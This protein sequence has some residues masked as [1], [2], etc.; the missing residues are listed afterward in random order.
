M[1]VPRRAL[2][3]LTIVACI[4][5]LVMV[6][7]SRAT[8]TLEQDREIQKA[9]PGIVEAVKGRLGSLYA[10]LTFNLTTGKFVIPI[11]PG[12]S[13]AMVEGAIDRAPAVYPLVQHTLI[14]LQGSAASLEAELHPL[15]A[16]GKAQVMVDE[17]A[18][19]PRVYYA[20]KLPTETKEGVKAM[21]ASYGG[22]AS[23]SPTLLARPDSCSIAMPPKEAGGYCDDQPFGG[24][25]IWETP[26]VR[27]PGGDP[28][29]HAG[30]SAGFVVKS[31]QTP[32]I[33]TAGHCVKDTKTP[34]GTWV[35]REVWRCKTPPYGECALV[36]PYPPAGECI[37]HVGP[38]QQDEL[39]DFG[40]RAG[41]PA[42]KRP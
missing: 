20:S 8:V 22:A 24:V 25:T 37:L 31:G 41:T 6:G 28:L 39:G 32:V 34:S 3:V 42:K 7:E 30:C 29:P 12:A 40:W 19:K 5:F 10:G 18:N 27:D 26:Y 23:S 21:A 17:K 33:L 15:I 38:Y 9:H 11:A 36:A 35:P 16:E 13:K 4:S 2:W 1:R 14:E